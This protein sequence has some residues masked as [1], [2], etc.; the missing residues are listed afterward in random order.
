M[1]IKKK[2]NSLVQGIQKTRRPPI[3]RCLAAKRRRDEKTDGRETVSAS[4]CWD[5]T[6]AR[7]EGGGLEAEGEEK[8]MSEGRG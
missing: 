1:K 4:V 7:E 5:G 8:D 3:T 2:G 6:G